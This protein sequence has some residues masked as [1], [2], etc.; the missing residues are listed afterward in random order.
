LKVALR[1][2]GFAGTTAHQGLLLYGVVPRKASQLISDEQIAGWKCFIDIVR[3]YVS[4]F[5]ALRVIKRA[6]NIHA[7]TQRKQSRKEN[8]PAFPAKA[9][10]CKVRKGHEK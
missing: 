6:R 9:Q 5:A 1:L 8:K 3:S 4:T 10:S 2:R 7:K